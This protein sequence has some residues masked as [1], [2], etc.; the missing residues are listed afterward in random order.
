MSDVD[1]DTSNQNLIS[2][3]NYPPNTI[4][5]IPDELDIEQQQYINNKVIFHI[6]KYPSNGHIAYRNMCHE[7]YKHTK[8]ACRTRFDDVNNDE[9][10]KDLSAVCPG[11]WRNQNVIVSNADKQHVRQVNN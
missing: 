10:G 4:T 6:L 2:R 8:G 7:C 9:E 3:L 11:I 1:V 5:I